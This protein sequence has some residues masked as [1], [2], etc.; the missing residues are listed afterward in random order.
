MGFGINPVCNGRHTCALTPFCRFLTNAL[1]VTCVS[2]TS[3]LIQPWLPFLHLSKH[4]CPY[5]PPHPLN[6]DFPHLILRYRAAGARCTFD[7]VVMFCHVYMRWPGPRSV[8]TH[9]TGSVKDSNIAAAQSCHGVT[10]SG[11]ISSSSLGDRWAHFVCVSG[12]SD[13]LIVSSALAPVEWRWLRLKIT[14][15]ILYREALA[16]TSGP[17]L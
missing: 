14:H 16:T 2:L 5:T 12:S 8:L 9:V 7:F 1:C 4:R 10:G 13:P 17:H 3:A 6:V 15:L 11:Q